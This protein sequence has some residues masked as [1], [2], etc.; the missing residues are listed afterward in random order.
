M[1]KSL[2]NNPEERKRRSDLMKGLQDS[3]AMTTPE[4]RKILSE[5]AKKTSARPEIQQQRA[6]QLQRWRDGYPEDF[7]TKCI[8]KMLAARPTE[9]SWFSKPETMLYEMLLQCPDFN[10][11]FNQVVKS[12]KF[13]WTSK[14]KQV[15]MADKQKGVY[16]EY[17]GPYHFKLFNE[18]GR[19]K[20]AE[21]RRRDQLLNE[22]VIENG[23]LLIR[24]SY[25]Q[26]LCRHE[27]SRFIPECITEI[28]DILY[29]DKLGVFRIGKHYE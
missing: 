2:M 1:S 6:A 5:S 9:P 25:D 24:I 20:L 11:R 21:T 16:V 28:L 15:D 12:D 17:D 27:R 10:F 29:S 3:G 19:E 18:S 8:D 26:Y 4:I 22:Y 14:R 13:D 7:K 23:L